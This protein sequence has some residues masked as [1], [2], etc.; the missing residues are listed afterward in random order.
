MRDIIAAATFVAVVFTALPASAQ[1]NDPYDYPYCL[2]GKDYGLPGLCQFT[3]YQQCRA[4]A[5]ATS[6]YCGTNPRFAYG[7]QPYGQRPYQ[8]R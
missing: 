6:S 4:A 8:V 5:S 7:W 2:Q 3:S 1:P